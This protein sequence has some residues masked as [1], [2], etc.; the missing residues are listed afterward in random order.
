M[1]SFGL[2]IWVKADLFE[3]SDQINLVNQTGKLHESA[4]C[5]FSNPSDSL[6]GILAN[7]Q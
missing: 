3:F 6:E 4:K 5:L 2:K 1:Q 7:V